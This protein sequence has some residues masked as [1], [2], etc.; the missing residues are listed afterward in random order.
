MALRAGAGVAATVAGCGAADGNVGDDESEAPPSPSP[1][2]SEAP[3]T[4][5]ASSE[6][7]STAHS[8]VESQLRTL[9]ELTRILVPPTDGGGADAEAVPEYLYSSVGL[10]VRALYEALGD[11]RRAEPLEHLRKRAKTGRFNTVRLRALE[12]FVL[13]VGGAGLSEKD[14]EFL[15]DFLDVWDG[16][17]AGM[18]EDAGHHATLRYAFPSVTAFKDAI[19]DDLDAAALDAGWKKVKLV[20]GSVA[21]EAYF[22][23]VL[24]VIRALMRQKRDSIQLWSGVAGPAAASDKRETPM[25]GDAFI[26]CEE[27]VMKN[28]QELS[29]VL[30]LHV[31]SD[32]SQ[33]SWSGGKFTF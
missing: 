32:S 11:A 8:A 6:S 12:R 5:L 26:L 27:L 18:A 24:Q 16:T 23:D 17:K 1:S 33:L 15:Y 31:F 28:Q 3:A 22:R 2:R 9:L 7:G 10:H 4:P 30:G 13:Q 25:D 14:Q 19:R 29:C 20:E 21:Y